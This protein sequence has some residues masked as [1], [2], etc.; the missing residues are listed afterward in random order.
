MR[1]VAVV[2]I[3]TFVLAI[4]V[5]SERQASAGGVD[6]TGTWTFSVT[7]EFGIL[8]QQTLVCTAELEQMGNDVGADFECGIANGD[9]TG[10]LTQ[11][12]L[13]AEIEAELRL[14]LS[15]PFPDID[16]HAVGTVSPN[17]NYMEGDWDADEYDGTFF[18]HRQGGAFLN[19]D[20][21]CDTSIN[22]AD[23][24]VAVQFLADVDVDQYP[25]CPEIGSSFAS[26]FGDMNCSDSISIA[27]VLRVLQ[28][29]AGV[30]ETNV[31]GCP[32]VGET[33]FKN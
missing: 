1:A 21:N 26:L 28:H 15:S 3:L 10:S 22:A 12:E 5:F 27:D 30:S 4:G 31:S 6:L 7:G 29:T 18:A 24:L 11:Q 20:L 16:A 14:N 8:G 2:V 32:E 9:A 23:A 19:G 17:G 33:I 13:G 25:G